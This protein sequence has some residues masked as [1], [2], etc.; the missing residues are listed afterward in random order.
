[1]TL[2]ALQAK[3]NPRA[4]LDFAFPNVDPGIIPY[5]HRLLVQ[6]RTPRLKSK[7]GIILADESKETELW[8]TQVGI[9]RAI[10]PLAFKNR[11]TMAPWAE[12]AWCS[13]GEFI[14]VPKYGGDRWKVPLAGGS[15]DFALFVIFNDV[16]IIG[17]V[18]V[19]PLTVEAYVS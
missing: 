14:R 11:T 17:K 6:I 3:I 8:N 10:G 12:G 9:V 5:G 1:M 16:D 18:T 4:G 15:G 19:D 2:T 7:G 13:E